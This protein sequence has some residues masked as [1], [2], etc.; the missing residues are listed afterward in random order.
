[1]D[2]LFKFS[3]EIFNVYFSID[4]VNINLWIKDNNKE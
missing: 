4:V 1:M 3:S 2:Q